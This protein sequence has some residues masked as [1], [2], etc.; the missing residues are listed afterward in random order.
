MKG[1]FYIHQSMDVE[2]VLKVANE[3]VFAK[4][5]ER[6]SDIQE[7]I[8]QGSW[9]GQNYNQI[10]ETSGYTR[11]HIGNEGSELWKLLTQAL[12]EKVSKKSFRAALERRS[13]LAEVPIP[14]EQA[15]EK[16]PSKNLDF[17]EREEAIA[18]SSL[19][20]EW[21]TISS[22]N[23]FSHPPTPKNWQ[24]RSQEIQQL[25]DWF[26]DTSINTIGIQGLS[27]IGKSW[28]AAKVYQS[29]LFESRFWADV[30]QKPDFTVFAKNA[31]KA[32]TGKSS[33]EV[34]QL[35]EL[36]LLINNLLEVAKQQRCLLVIDNLETL[37]DT[38]RVF[39][40]SYRDFFQAWLR[41]GS[42]SKLLLTSQTIPFIMRNNCHWLT[43]K[44]LAETE[45]AQLLQ[46][47]GVQ[48]TKT[49]LQE[50]TRYLD[51]HPALL[52]F[53]AA[54]L[55]RDT[56]IGEAEKLGLSQLDQLFEEVEG[57]YRDQQ[58]VRCEHLLALHYERLT[59]ELQQF[60]VNLSIYQHP[61]FN[62]DAAAI[63]F[64]GQDAPASPNKTQKALHELTSCSL[65]E[66]IEVKE[67]KQYQFPLIVWKYAKQKVGEQAEA[68]REK[69]VA[70]Y[71]S[72]AAAESTW[73]T[74]E[75]VTPYLEIFYHRYEQKQ[76]IQAYNAL[77]SCS[78]FLSLRGYYALVAERYE[79][80]VQVWKPRKAQQQELA[81]ALVRLGRTYF[82]LGQYPEAIEHC[83]QALKIAREVV[84]RH[85]EAEATGW[86]GVAYN[87]SGQYRQA[88]KFNRR[89]LR[90]ARAINYHKQKAD[91]L[92]NIGNNYR[93]LRRYQRAIKFY[94]L[95]RVVSRE[96]GYLRCEP[97]ALNGLGLI[98]DSLR[99]CSQAIVLYEQTL[100]VARASGHYQRE[101]A[102]LR[103]ISRCLNSWGQSQAAIWYGQQA[104][105][106]E[107]EIGNHIG[108]ADALSWLGKAYRSLRQYKQAIECYERAIRIRELMLVRGK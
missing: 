44:G 20:N 68:L 73:K 97:A 12:E 63:V 52:R 35:N 91:A 76:Y 30:S 85:I 19:E 1:N 16:T 50:F 9:Q 99:Q 98:Y 39:D 66:E 95:G 89:S 72:L 88:L 11:S 36:E 5:K 71:Q 96:I 102:A 93:I 59:P 74:M 70:Y 92:V 25:T 83:E 49:E 87:A 3:A 53:V 32:L 18:D 33:E 60:V 82:N 31:L 28:L 37:L 40:W 75:D 29:E 86:L 104:L 51:G 46:E 17:V 105:K 4:T 94:E 22:A 58:R 45:G 57:D 15:Q 47:L 38:E 108:E 34:D 42:T 107:R 43:L 79:Q 14:Q 77:Y 101:A 62:R 106:I 65:L 27:G 55:G 41:C 23:L 90:L 21:L 103:H 56:H 64:P 2:E 26:A 8:L 84:E 54:Y 78:D 81:T 6:L 80:L 61:R 13:H 24:G 67:E 100:M 7:Y 10:A 48:G 69:V